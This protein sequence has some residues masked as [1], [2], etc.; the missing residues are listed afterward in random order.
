MGQGDRGAGPVIVLVA[1]QLGE[2]IG[3]AARAMANFGLSRLRLVNPRDGWPNS[4]AQRSASRADHVIDAVEVFDSLEAAVADLSFVYATTRRERGIVKP[5]VGPKEAGAAVHARNAAG[6]EV[7]ILFGRERWGLE[8]DEVALADEILTLPVVPEFA[9]LNIAQAVLVVAYEWRMA[10]TDE[11]AA[12]PFATAGEPP[13]SKEDL[14]GLFEHL[15]GALDR[16]D[17]F[18]PPEKRPSMV[19]NLRAILQKGEF[20]GPEVK[21]LR[22]VV[23]A[24]DKGPMTKA[25]IADRRKERRDQASV[26]AGDGRGGEKP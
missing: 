14:V 9:S 16:V 25:D 1:P 23:A 26:G 24:L 20:T 17:F 8:N 6:Q 12:L 11:V 15:E 10:G 2:N 7:G 19:R 13:A 5:V 3:A 4:Q 18:R 21:A 22:G